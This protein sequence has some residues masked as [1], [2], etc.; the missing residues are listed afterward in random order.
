MA[1]TLVGVLALLVGA[2][3]LGL[4]SREGPEGRLRSS[5]VRRRLSEGAAVEVTTYEELKAAIANSTIPTIQILGD[6]DFSQE[7]RGELTIP[8][9]RS[10]TIESFVGGRLLGGSESRFFTVEGTL[11]LQYLVLHRGMAS[12][13]GAVRVLPTGRL[14]AVKCVFSGN[15]AGTK[16]GATKAETEVHYGEGGA[17]YSEGK[18][19]VHRSEFL[20]NDGVGAAIHS[21]KSASP[22][23]VA[24][25]KVEDSWFGS[26]RSPTG[27]GGAI[28]NYGRAEVLRCLFDTNFAELAGGAILSASARAP[29]EAASLNVT[30]S[31]F[32]RNSA[33]YGDLADDLVVRSGKVQGDMSCGECQ[34]VRRAGGYLNGF[35]AP[36]HCDGVDC[37]GQLFHC[38]KSSS[39]S[40]APSIRRQQRGRKSLRD[41]SPLVWW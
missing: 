7:D 8:E 20:A 12:Q 15:R 28:I 6:V 19:S 17:I 23:V 39:N 5:A 3:V 4:W 10:V 21:G 1:R 40:R 32:Q 29:L 13:G 33:G 27:N 18:I 24:D 25:A 37:P 11:V 35:C 16:V 14:E 38:G 2:A 41:H 31:L 34:D 30:G 22:E 9:S 26:N 36:L